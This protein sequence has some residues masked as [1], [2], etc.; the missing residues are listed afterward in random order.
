MET[1]FDMKMYNAR[2]TE[3]NG[4]GSHKSDS[5]LWKNLSN[6]LFWAD[7]LITIANKT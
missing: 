5:F 2:H 6:I 3:G 7:I 4:S 1:Y